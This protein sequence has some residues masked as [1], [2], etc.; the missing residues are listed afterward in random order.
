MIKKLVLRNYRVF[1]E[2]QLDLH[3]DMNILVG[4]NDAG[5][6]TL[7]EAINLALTG[8]LGRYQ[9]AQDISPYL[10]NAYAV[11]EYIDGLKAGTNPPPPELVVELYLK[12]TAECAHL[13]GTNNLLGED[14]PGV[15]VKVSF[16]EE[17]SDEY[18]D[19]KSVV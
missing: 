13:R 10:F 7:L 19:R 8:R 16:D 1:R 15:K 6:S 18:L 3:P 9:L 2:F 17:F 12:D 11:R 14:T 4:D 5:K